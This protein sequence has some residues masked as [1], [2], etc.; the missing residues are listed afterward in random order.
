LRGYQRY[1]VLESV[2]ESLAGGNLVRRQLAINKNAVLEFVQ[3]YGTV[4]T[5]EVAEVFGVADA[6]ADA[7][8]SQLVATKLIAR[9]PAG[10][11]NLY[12]DNPR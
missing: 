5:R 7:I 3:K 6:Q 12:L 1:K 4:A 2:I 8:L 9:R 10:T 11:G